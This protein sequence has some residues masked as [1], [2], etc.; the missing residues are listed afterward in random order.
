MPPPPSPTPAGAAVPVV[1]D[2]VVVGG[3]P[4]GLAAA[5]WLARYRRGGG[6]VDAGEQ[7]ARRVERSH[8]SLGRDPQRPME[9]VAVAR[10]QL[11]GYP[12]ASHV[13]AEVV[14][15]RQDGDRFVIVL[16]DGR[17][18]SALRVVLAT[19]VADVFPAI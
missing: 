5:T 19:G 10:S 4:A 17:E 3:G 16:A 7:R 2:A 15:A 13:A 11:L 1:R 18:L 12:T 9:F 14:R 8:G 6:L